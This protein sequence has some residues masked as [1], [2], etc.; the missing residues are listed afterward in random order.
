MLGPP[1]ASVGSRVGEQLEGLL[2]DRGLGGQL[3]ELR[4]ILEERMEDLFS[5]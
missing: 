1:D 4:E 2:L 5:D 3:E